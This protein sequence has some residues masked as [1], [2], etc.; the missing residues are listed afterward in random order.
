MRRTVPGL[1]FCL[2]TE[3]SIRNPWPTGPWKA[4]LPYMILTTYFGVR[5]FPT[6]FLPGANELARHWPRPRR[7]AP[8]SQDH[9]LLGEHPVNEP[10]GPPGGQGQCPD[11]LARVVAA[12]EVARHLGSIGPR[13][14]GALPKGLIPC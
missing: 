6:G 1:S 11:G 4:T 8:A 2:V 10:V 9:P 14:P 3:G 12:L 13:H 7:P 5:R